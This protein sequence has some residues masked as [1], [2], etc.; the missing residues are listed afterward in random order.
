MCKVSGKMVDVRIV[1]HHGMWAVKITGGFG[2]KPVCITERLDEARTIAV[3]TAVKYQL[4]VL[5][6]DANG[7]FVG[8]TQWTDLPPHK[9]GWKK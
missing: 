6:Y 9:K 5:E 2:K 3:S 8:E 7:T 1:P 4:P